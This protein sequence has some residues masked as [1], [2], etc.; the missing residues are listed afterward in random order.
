MK[1]FKLMYKVSSEQVTKNNSPK[2]LDICNKILKFLRCINYNCFHIL[3]FPMTN[4]RVVA[5]NKDF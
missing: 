5:N 3:K 4:R 1:W 2:L